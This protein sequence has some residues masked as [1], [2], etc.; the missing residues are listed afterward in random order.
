MPYANYP[1]VGYMA[2]DRSVW[3]VNIYPNGT[4]LLEIL[5]AMTLDKVPVSCIVFRLPVRNNA[6]SLRRVD[7]ASNYIFII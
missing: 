1:A 7:D 5:L 4:E 3:V 6:S 2:Y